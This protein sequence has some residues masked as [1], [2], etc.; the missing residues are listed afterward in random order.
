MII[1]ILNIERIVINMFEISLIY[2]I[3]RVIPE[4]LSFVWAFYTLSQTKI[5]M[6]RYFLSVITMVILICG[7]KLL[8]IHFGIHTLLL[9]VGIII[10][11]IF[12]NKID[13]IKSIL[14][15][16][17]VIII[18]FISEIIDLFILQYL[19]KADTEYIFS[20]PQLK[21]LYGFPTFIFF[22]FFIIILKS[23]I[24]KYRK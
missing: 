7:V 10:V 17:S 9:M 19:F 15:T 1:K 23:L 12:I 21:V 8:P 11:N 14:V 20:N 5:I 18:E 13:I 4:T 2:L 22:V 24:N 16:L 6:N 3:G